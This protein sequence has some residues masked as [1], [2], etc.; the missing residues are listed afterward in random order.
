MQPAALRIVFDWL[1]PSV[2]GYLRVRGAQDPEGLTNDV[3]LR[4]YR[5]I[6]SFEGDQSSFRSWVFTITHNV[7]IDEHRKRQRQVPVVALDENHDEPVADV[8]VEFLYQAGLDEVARMLAPLTADQRTVL[9]LRIVAGLSLAESA[10][11]TQR[12]AGAVKALQHRGLSA[13][14]RFADE[15]SRISSTQP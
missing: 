15:Q 10:A 2:A 3:F 13:L 5:R 9:Y 14:R 6:G 11:V 1:A 4:V 12:D 8:E 7:L